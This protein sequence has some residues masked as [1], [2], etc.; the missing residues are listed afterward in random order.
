M[1]KCPDDY[2]SRW[3]SVL[4][5]LSISY[6]CN[7]LKEFNIG[8]G[9]IMFLIEL[10]HGDGISQEELSSCLSIDRA[11]TT[12]AISKLEHEGYI[13]RK[14]DENDRRA[15]K[16]YVTE[17]GLAIK[18]QILDLMNGW[19]S[20]VSDALSEEE[21]AVFIGM[22]KKVGCSVVDHRRFTSCSV[23]VPFNIKKSN[24]R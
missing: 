8:S 9:Q 4:H 17:K 13:L 15:Y 5:R 12:R 19:E 18:S 7:G 11:N 20:V 24:R 1:E 2:I 14:I 10:Y 6:V 22:L 23:D 21:K 16:I 3:F